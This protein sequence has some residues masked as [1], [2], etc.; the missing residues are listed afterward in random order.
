MWLWNHVSVPQI[1]FVRSFLARNLIK[2]PIIIIITVVLHKRVHETLNVILYFRIVLKCKQ[3]EIILSDIYILVPCSMC[4]KY[5]LIFT[6]I[7][8]FFVNCNC[9]FYNENTFTFVI[10][11]F[12]KCLFG[13]KFP[14]ICNALWFQHLPFS[15]C[16]VCVTLSVVWK[17]KWALK[18]TEVSLE[19]YTICSTD[20]SHDFITLIIFKNAS[21]ELNISYFSKP[22]H[23][24]ILH[25]P[26]VQIR[27]KTH[28]AVSSTVKLLVGTFQWKTF[29]DWI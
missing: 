15:R 23:I 14:F 19:K 7:F 10:K 9:R 1:D 13:I 18:G 5:I 24:H 27:R 16:N 21:L 22:K 6:E 28:Q 26:A 17:R 2:W 4:F 12:Y 29:N 20:Y 3:I 25:R 8:F 11:C